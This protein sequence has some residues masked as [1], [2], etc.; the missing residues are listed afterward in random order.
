MESRLRQALEEDERIY[1]TTLYQ[2]NRAYSEP[3]PQRTHQQSQVYST[4]MAS[5]RSSPSSTDQSSLSH[6]RSNPIAIS[7]PPAEKIKDPTGF[8]TD[9]DE[10]DYDDLDVVARDAIRLRKK[11]GNS[12]VTA[13]SS[14]QPGMGGELPSQTPRTLLKA[15]YLGSLSKSESHVSSLPPIS[16]SEDP[17]LYNYDDEPPMEIA[18][19]GSLRESHQRG[20]FLDGPSSYR[21]PRSGQVRRLDRNRFPGGLSKSL[22]PTISIGERIQQNQKRNSTLK[23]RAEVTDHEMGT[24]GLAVVLNMA[25]KHE[26]ENENALVDDKEGSERLEPLRLPVVNGT[27]QIPHR[28]SAFGGED[29][30]A[31]DTFDPPTM[32]STSMTAFEVLHSTTFQRNITHSQ[33]IQENFQPLAR[34]MSD[35]TPNHLQHSTMVSPNTLQNLNAL[36]GNGV[37]LGSPA[38]AAYPTEGDVPHFWTTTGSPCITG[39]SVEGALLPPNTW[40]PDEPHDPDKDAAFDMDME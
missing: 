27:E 39:V 16:L 34:T 6:V 8:E 7:R 11:Y 22:Q 13:S 24:S 10:D 31:Y 28:L 36:D 35:P 32:M 19:Y 21:E 3:A 14:Y 37:I 2:E 40:A 26:N 18:S 4:S 12:V 5:A 33:V 15:P 20:K 38:I 25:S 23:Q 9:E 30:E 1:D 29:E 17:T